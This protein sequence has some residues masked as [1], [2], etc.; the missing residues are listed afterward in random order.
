MAV[1]RLDI[2]V[3]DLVQRYLA[4]ESEKSL[5]ERYQIA[6][7][8]IRA[9]LRAANIEP[10]GRSEAMYV[11]MAQTIPEERRRLAEAAHVMRRGQRDQPETVRVRTQ[12]RARTNRSRAWIIGRGELELFD[13]LTDHGLVAKSQQAVGPYN[14]DISVGNVAVEVHATNN[15]PRSAWGVPKRIEYLTERRWQVIYL[16]TPKA[17]IEERC[18]DQMIALCERLDGLPPVRGEYWVIRGS[19]NRRATAGD[20]THHVTAESSACARENSRSGH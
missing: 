20:Y 10:R 6:R 2:D 13:Y 3:D 17:V 14:I 5:S 19:T 7:N 15:H 12:R 8:G 4:G 18:L 9:R 1:K 11:R 16:W